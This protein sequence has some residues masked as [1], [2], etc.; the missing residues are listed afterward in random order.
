MVVT[1]FGSELGACNVADPRVDVIL[2]VHVLPLCKE[3]DEGGVMGMERTHILSVLSEHSV[4]LYIY[5]R[6]INTHTTTTT[7]TI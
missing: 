6:I 4:P 3:G 5:N 1:L 2:L 7:T